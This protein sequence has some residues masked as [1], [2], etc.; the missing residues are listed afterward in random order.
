[1]MENFYKVLGLKQGASLKEISAAYRAQA[2]IHHP[3]KRK[4]ST[5]DS[6]SDEKFHKIKAAYQALQ[7]PKIRAELDLQLI[8][9]EERA[10]RDAQMS[11]QRK[12][13]RDDL[14]NREKEASNSKKRNFLNDPQVVKE[15]SSKKT[16]NL[17]FERLIS[18][19]DACLIFKCRFPDNIDRKLALEMIKSSVDPVS[20]H[21]DSSSNST[22]AAE[23]RT[24][25]DAYRALCKIPNDLITKADW[26][27]G[28][29]PDGLKLEFAQTTATPAVTKN[30]PKPTVKYSKELEESILERLKRKK[31]DKQDKIN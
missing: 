27:K 3:D 2:L 28:Y 19:Q 18:N 7:D 1:M 4:S 31:L 6:K 13:L 16:H 10:K 14:L 15:E 24:P 20:L 23:F 22:L 29:P 5:M 30:E 12:Q 26:Y 25:Q 11:S 21:E 9:L 8:G 17:G